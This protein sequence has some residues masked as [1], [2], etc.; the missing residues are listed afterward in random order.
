MGCFHSLR[1]MVAEV[2]I[3]V[4]NVQHAVKSGD[5]ATVLALLEGKADVS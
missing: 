1:D 4:T 2:D 5:V 3:L